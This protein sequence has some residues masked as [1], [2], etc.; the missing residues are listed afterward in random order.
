M[1]AEA[2]VICESPEVLRLTFGPEQANTYIIAQDHHAVL[3]D[4]CS[5]DVLSELIGRD[6]IPDAVLLTHEHADHLWGLN[7]VREAFPDVKVIAQSECSRAICD[8]VKNK[9]SQYLIYAA[10]RFGENYRNEEVKNRRYFCSPADIEYID[11]FEFHWHGSTMKLVHAPGH[12]PGSSLIFLGDSIVFS[13]DLMLNDKTFLQF[14]GGDAIQ[15]LQISMPLIRS[16]PT[17]TIICPGHGKPFL[18]EEWKSD[19]E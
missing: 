2:S 4:V 9:A 6:I 12:S 8:P 15:F 16:I 11:S 3:I 5:K 17:E 14:D 18:K 13:G 19:Y 1:P 10:L 7:A